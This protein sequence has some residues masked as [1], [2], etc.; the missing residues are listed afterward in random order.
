MHLVDDGAVKKSLF[1]QVRHY[2]QSKLL[3]DLE[4]VRHHHK[5]KT[6]DDYIYNVVLDEICDHTGK[7]HENVFTLLAYLPGGRLQTFDNVFVGSHF[8]RWSRWG[9][10][11]NAGIRNTEYRW[12]NL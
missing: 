5:D 2:N 12:A 10:P 8:L 11:Y 1:I 4:H 6:K 3:A 9:S 7:L